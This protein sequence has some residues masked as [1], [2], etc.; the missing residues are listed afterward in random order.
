[1]VLVHDDDLGF[2]KR[3]SDDTVSLLTPYRSHLD[4][5]FHVT[6]SLETLQ[7]DVVKRHLRILKPEARHVVYG[8][9]LLPSVS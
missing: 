7:A 2:I 1:M 5:Y 6:K 4:Y 8:E 3:I 9:Y